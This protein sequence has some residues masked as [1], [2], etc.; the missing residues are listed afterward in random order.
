MAYGT[1]VLVEHVS[2]TRGGVTYGVS[3][4][5]AVVVAGLVTGNYASRASMSPATRIAM[6]RTWELFGYLANSL[7]FV[8]IGLQIQEHPFHRTDVLYI[9]AA[10][11]GVL[12]SRALV[13]Y[14]VSGY[15]NWRLPR[16]RRIP[17]AF[18]HV[19]NWGGMRGALALA[20]ALSI[21]A[22]AI[23]ERP[24][25]LLMTFSVVLFTLLV[26]GLTIRPL[27]AALGLSGHGQS[28]NVA[29]F[30]RLQAQLLATQAAHRA[31]TDPVTAS[32]LGPDAHAQ[33]LAA[34]DARAAHIRQELDG[35]HVSDEELRA[36]R[37]QIAQR[38]ALQAEKDTLLALRNRGTI[39]N[40][41]Y[42]AL[43]AEVDARLL[44][45]DE[46]DA[47]TDLTPGPAPSLERSE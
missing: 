1:F 24:T 33:L 22:A 12:V 30:E 11:A 23:P 18:Q 7:I 43:A 8:L 41:V 42:R 17:L 14:G 5:I 13:V 3:P 34:Y 31:L 27:V 10:I 40:S 19:I 9:L 36:E 28:P 26:Q 32:D 4:V 6:D 2:V 38:R 37:M 35:L 45:L 16:A 15:M 39:T 29:A 21:P 47:P 20:A 46:T 44:Q 25:L